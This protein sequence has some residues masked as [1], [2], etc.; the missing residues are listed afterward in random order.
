MNIVYSGH[1]DK[2]PEDQTWLTI[3]AAAQ[4][5][6]FGRNTIERATLLGALTSQIRAGKR[7]IDKGSLISYREKLIQLARDEFGEARK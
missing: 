2:P 1:E 4:L 3:S 5:V 6:G 7:V